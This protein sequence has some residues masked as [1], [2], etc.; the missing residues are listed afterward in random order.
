MKLKLKDK[1]G[2]TYKLNDRVLDPTYNKEYIIKWNGY[3]YY[4]YGFYDRY[5]DNPTDF[6]GEFHCAGCEIVR[7]FNNV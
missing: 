6:F 4:A 1:N 2:V 7:R 5:Q 3:S